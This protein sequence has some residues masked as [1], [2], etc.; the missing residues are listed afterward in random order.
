[1]EREVRLGNNQA[2]TSKPQKWHVPS[3]KQQRLHEPVILN[4][5]ETK[6]PKHD[7]ILQKKKK[8]T[9]CRSRF[10]PRAEVNRITN[11]ITDNYLDILADAADCKCR[12]VLLMKKHSVRP[13]PDITEVSSYTEITTIEHTEAQKSIY[14]LNINFYIVIMKN[15]IMTW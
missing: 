10:D 3:K 13:N 8:N 15:M 9:V 6:K 4:E 12:I 14:N 7:K 5:I 11:A 2:C 1:M